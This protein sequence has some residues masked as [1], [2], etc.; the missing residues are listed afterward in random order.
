VQQSTDGVNYATIA[1]VKAK[2]VASAYSIS[3]PQAVKE[4]FYR[5]GMEDLDGSIAYSGVT[6][7]TLNC[8]SSS[9]SLSVFPNPTTSGSDITVKYTV[10]QTKGEAQLQIFDMTGKRVESVTVQVSGGVNIYSI[11]AAGLAQGAYTLFVVGDGW[12]SDGVK[13]VRSN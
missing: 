9:E 12:R 13:V 1:F 6:D 11:S 4:A 10:P 8:L 7:L 3:I 5:I 2:G